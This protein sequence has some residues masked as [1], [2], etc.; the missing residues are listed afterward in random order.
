M[1]Y[2]VSSNFDLFSVTLHLIVGRRGG[3]KLQF[4]DFFAGKFI[5]NSFLNHNKPSGNISCDFPPILIYHTVTTVLIPV[6]KLLY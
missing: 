3:S 2:I 1:Y 4:M 5:N 6:L